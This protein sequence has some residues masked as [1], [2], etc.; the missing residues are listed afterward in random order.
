M[1]VT[2]CAVSSAGRTRAQKMSNLSHLTFNSSIFSLFLT[3]RVSGVHVQRTGTE[4]RV[5]LEEVSLAVPPL[6]GS[7]VGSR[8]RLRGGAPVCPPRDP[9]TTGDFGQAEQRGLV[10][11]QLPVVQLVRRLRSAGSSRLRVRL[12][13]EAVVLFTGTRLLHPAVLAF[14]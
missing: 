10:A 6:E 1:I 9:G 13:P 8:G 5:S 12:R 14:H 2:N 11:S 4:R 7:A 3:H